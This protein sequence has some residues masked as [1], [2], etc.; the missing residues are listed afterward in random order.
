MPAG[1]EELTGWLPEWAVTLFYA[2]GAIGAALV[3]VRSMMKGA[4]KVTD[5]SAAD[6][7]MTAVSSV[8]HYSDRMTHDALITAIGDL[9]GTII[10]F[11][12]TVRLM[13]DRLD[14]DRDERR[15]REDLQQEHDLND[16]KSMIQAMKKDQRRD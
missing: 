8:Q 3:M 15:L 6:R 4:S 11:H 5:G 10:E 12:G 9:H 14:K 1:I 13:S 2:L 16:L 7:A